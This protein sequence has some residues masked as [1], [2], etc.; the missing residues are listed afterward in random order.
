MNGNSPGDY[1]ERPFNDM[2]A[3]VI[4]SQLDLF[5][6][7][8]PTDGGSFVIGKNQDILDLGQKN[9]KIS[10]TLGDAQTNSQGQDIISFKLIDEN[11]VEYYFEDLEVTQTY[12]LNDINS[13]YVSS[14]YLTRIENPGKPNDIIEFIYQS[15]ALTN[16]PTTYSQ[17][18]HRQFGGFTGSEVS[19]SSS[20]QDVYSKRLSQIIL[21]DD[22]SVNFNYSNDSYF[23]AAGAHRLQNISISDGDKEKEFDLVHDTSLNRLTLK[24]VIPMGFDEESEGRYTFEYNGSMPSSMGVVPDHWGYYNGNGTGVTRIPR[25]IFEG[26]LPNTGVYELPGSNRDT[27]STYVKRGSLKKINYPTGGY[28]IYDMEANQSHDERL[29]NEFTVNLDEPGY[30]NQSYTGTIDSDLSWGQNVFDIYYS[31]DANSVTPFEI[32]ISQGIFNCSTCKVTARLYSSSNYYTAPVKQVDISLYGYGN[33]IGEFNV[34]N[35][36]PGHTYKL[37]FDTNS[38]QDYYSYVTVNWREPD[39]DLTPTKT[40]RHIQD[41]VGGLRVKRIMSYDGENST[42]VLQKHYNYVMEDNET[43]SGT[44]GEYP[45]YSYSVYYQNRATGTN[46]SGQP[47]G[48]RAPLSAPEN[49]LNSSP[50]V[51]VRSSSPIFELPSYQGSPVIYERVV[52]TE[53]DGQGNTL[54]KEVKYFSNYDEMPINGDYSLPYTPADQKNWSYGLLRKHIILDAQNDTLKSIY[55][56]YDFSLDNYATSPVRLKNFES[57]SITP[58]MFFTGTYIPSST[59]LPPLGIPIYFFSENFYPAAGR[60]D[61]IQKIVKTHTDSGIITS[62]IDYEIDPEFFKTTQVTSHLST[63]ELMKKEYIYAF[64]RLGSQDPSGMHQRFYNQNNLNE[65]VQERTT[66]D[67]SNAVEVQKEYTGFSNNWAKLSK[68]KSKKGSSSL[69][70]RILYTH[71]DNYGNP[72]E[73]QQVDGAPV[74]YLWSYDGQYPVAKIENASLSAVASALGVSQNYL[75]DYPSSAVATL[76]G[77]AFRNSL[78]GA[79]IT[80]YTYDPLIGMTS[81]TDPRGR[82]TTYEYDAYGRL[83]STRDADNYLL[84]EY[85]Y[86]YRNQ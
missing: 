19:S 43:S 7:S 32:I 5:S 44:L 6:Y 63:G 17:Q 81:M 86:H 72:V 65:V 50:N 22:I 61:L 23:S 54:G 70:D 3:N 34:S 42:P 49:Y 21:P 15:E 28:T 74:V 26:G 73:L 58:V 35:L 47:I 13:S 37:L 2:Y 51:I 85:K 30:N 75:L 59:E 14:W 20:S 53:E 82:K 83:E 48:W 55:N 57:V 84:E 79:L 25:E 12:P 27:D 66:V 71:Y 80:T 33:M 67:G 31:G 18:E 4:D 11:G 24:E 78:S 69:E 45:R 60:A 56:D 38:L 64:E 1:W 77:T 46:G 41:Y 16:Y 68:I 36:Q 29:H 40:Y 52:I 8:L 62:T 39:S 10:Y 76:Q 9:I